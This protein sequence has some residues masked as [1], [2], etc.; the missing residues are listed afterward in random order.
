MHRKKRRQQL[1]IKATNNRY[2]GHDFICLAP[3][4]YLN[5]QQNKGE[6]GGGGESREKEGREKECAYINCAITRH[7]FCSAL[8][9]AL[10]SHQVKRDRHHH[11]RHHRHYARQKLW[12]N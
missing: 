9:A 8:I 11:H 1:E 4:S 5:A 6:I 7:T 2:T 12:K 10:R 3:K